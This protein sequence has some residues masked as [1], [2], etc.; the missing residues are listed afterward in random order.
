MLRVAGQM[1]GSDATIDM[2]LG[3]VYT[4]KGGLIVRGR[5]YGSRDEALEAAGLSQ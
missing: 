3:I 5:E 1:K 4:V 2:R